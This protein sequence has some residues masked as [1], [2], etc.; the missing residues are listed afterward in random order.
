[1]GWW[2]GQPG[3]Q[4]L[5]GQ[6]GSSQGDPQPETPDQAG[7][8]RSSAWGWGRSQGSAPG[9]GTQEWSRGGEP[10]AFG[11]LHPHP[12]GG[13]GCSRAVSAYRCLPC[14]HH[15]PRTTSGSI[16]SP[17]HQESARLILAL[18]LGRA[19]SDPVSTQAHTGAQVLVA[20]ASQ[21]QRGWRPVS[22]GVLMGEFQGSVTKGGLPTSSPGIASLAQPPLC[23][24]WELASPGRAEGVG[25]PTATQA[26][27]QAETGRPK[28]TQQPFLEPY[29]PVGSLRTAGRRQSW[30]SKDSFRG[31]PKV[32]QKGKLRPGQGHGLVQGHSGDHG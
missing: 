9:W 2:P 31:G 11:P 13:G 19:E 27:L 20:T 3:V 6:S 21:Q 14:P 25:A 29:L 16:H 10:P 17:V 4:V 24:S 8:A 15:W 7:S 18:L 26:A 28:V 12:S 30:A 32:V 1:M 5:S 22:R 23:G